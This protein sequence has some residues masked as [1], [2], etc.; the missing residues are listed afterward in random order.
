[1]FVYHIFLAGYKGHGNGRNDA[2]KPQ[3]MDAYSESRKSVLA[4]ASVKLAAAKYILTAAK[5]KFTVTKTKFT[6]ARILRI[7]GLAEQPE[8]TRYRKNTSH[9]SENILS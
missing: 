9:C 3:R 8:P 6:A 5:T 1:M 2:K 4:T 7:K